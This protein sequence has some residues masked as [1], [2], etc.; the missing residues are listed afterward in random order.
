MPVQKMRASTAR[1][2]GG[3][4]TPAQLLK[5]QRS[6]MQRP[7]IKGAVQGESL[8]RRPRLKRPLRLLRLYTLGG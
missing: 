5:A 8:Y 2:E 7:K 4:K 3:L 1:R 6:K